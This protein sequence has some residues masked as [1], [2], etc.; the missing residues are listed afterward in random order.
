M[1]ALRLGFRQIKGFADTD[2]EAI[3]AAR[4][5]PFVSIDDFARRTGLA[6]P[7]LRRLADADAFRANSLTCYPYSL[8]HR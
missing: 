1:Q 6:T 2:A 3:L 5:R 8:A 7:A 4:D